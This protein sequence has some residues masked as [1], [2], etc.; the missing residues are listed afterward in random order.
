MVFDGYPT[1]LYSKYSVY[2]IQR[3]ASLRGKTL[4]PPYLQLRRHGNNNLL[5][6]RHTPG[7]NPK[8]LPFILSSS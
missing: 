1:I 3:I 6:L 7:P 2:S 5:L 4:M 8:G